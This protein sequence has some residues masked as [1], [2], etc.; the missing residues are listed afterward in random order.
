MLLSKW[1]G[2]EQEF[3]GNTRA[4][5]VIGIHIP[6]QMMFKSHTKEMTLSKISG[7]GDRL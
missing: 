2:A 1:R 5:A 7:D 3:R 6:A 4:E